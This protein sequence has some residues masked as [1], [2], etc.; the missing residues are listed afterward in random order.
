[1]LHET[2][3][4]QYVIQNREITKDNIQKYKMKI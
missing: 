1:M 2:R 4:E 3:C